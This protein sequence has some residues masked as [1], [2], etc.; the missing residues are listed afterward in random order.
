MGNRVNVVYGLPVNEKQGCDSH[1]SPILVSCADKSLIC[2]DDQRPP[3]T[4]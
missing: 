4:T 2:N 1:D 3:A